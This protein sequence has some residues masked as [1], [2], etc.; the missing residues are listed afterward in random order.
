MLVRYLC[1]A[2]TLGAM[3]LVVVEHDD[4]VPIGMTGVVE[5]FVRESDPSEPSPMMATALNAPPSTSRPA[6]IPSA[7]EIAVAA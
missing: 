3:D 4:D 7:A 5:P 6:A 2:P 1:M